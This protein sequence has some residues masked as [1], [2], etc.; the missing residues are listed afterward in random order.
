MN[1]ENS[2]YNRLVALDNEGQTVRVGNSGNSGADHLHY[3]IYVEDGKLAG[4]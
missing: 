1:K 4:Q 3:V 2:S